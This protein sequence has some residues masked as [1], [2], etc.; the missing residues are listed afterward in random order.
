MKLL[1]GLGNPGIEYES[2][3]HNLGCIALDEIIKNYDLKI[4]SQKFM[5]DIFIGEISQKIIAIK[6]KTFMN[7]SGKSVLAAKSFYK[8]ELKDILVFHDE[9]DLDLGKIKV[10]VG[11][12]NAGHNGLK[13][14]DATIGVGYTRIR[15]GIGRP[16]N[17][18]I[19]I[20]DYVLGKFNKTEREM[21]ENISKKVSDNLP[22]LLLEK[23]DSFLNKFYNR[24]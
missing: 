9:I 8:I 1:V 2:T 4:H 12:G 13:S 20:S 11:G 5:S 22:D 6:P 24:C 17:I 21:V 23:T 7:L 16:E 18:N 19:E 14:I 3:R 10:K 15:L